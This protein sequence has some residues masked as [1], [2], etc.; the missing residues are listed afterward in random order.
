MSKDQRDIWKL[1]CENVNKNIYN[2]KCPFCKGEFN[3][4]FTRVGYAYTSDE[5]LCPFCGYK[6]V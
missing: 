1:M 2:Y 3:A 5:R 4:P 6:M